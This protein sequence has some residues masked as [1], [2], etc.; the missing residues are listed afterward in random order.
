MPAL[1]LF[2]HMVSSRA[3]SFGPSSDPQVLIGSPPPR[4]LDAPTTIEAKVLPTFSNSLFSSTGSTK[5]PQNPYKFDNITREPIFPDIRYQIARINK[6]SI[7]ACT[8]WNRLAAQYERTFPCGHLSEIVK[9][10]EE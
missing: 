9:V 8:I 1:G 3:F 4:H 10:L 7:H 2:R 6:P 5:A